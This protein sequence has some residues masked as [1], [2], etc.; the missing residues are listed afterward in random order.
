M[1]GMGSGSYWNCVRTRRLVAHSS[2]EER[3]QKGPVVFMV[4]VG[5]RDA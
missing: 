5:L 1:G 2:H 4:P 3:N